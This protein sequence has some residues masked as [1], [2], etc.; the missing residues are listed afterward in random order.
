MVWLL[1]DPAGV[2]VPGRGKNGES[3]TGGNEGSGMGIWDLL[4]P[5][6]MEHCQT[7]Q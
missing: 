7:K 5:K 4:P 2:A 3:F 6:Q 1:L